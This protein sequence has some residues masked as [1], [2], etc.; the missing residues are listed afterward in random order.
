MI[1]LLNAKA[2]ANAATVVTAV[3]YVVCWMLSVLFPEVIF[4]IGRS[5]MH[6]ISLDSVRT[7]TQMPVLTA[8]WGLLTISAVTWV[9]VYGTIWL[10]NRWAR[11]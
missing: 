11:K 2:F 5:W 3:F 10:Y 8:I 9:T 4:N 1:K 7:T 6:T